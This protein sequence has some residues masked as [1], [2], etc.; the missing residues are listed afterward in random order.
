MLSLSDIFKYGSRLVK[1][2]KVLVGIE[3]KKDDHSENDRIVEI[4]KDQL[5]KSEAR[6]IE[7]D[8]RII[9]L[10]KEIQD[11]TRRLIRRGRK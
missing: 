4:L 11:L 6:E 8:K 1:A 10:E 3:D 2:G 7:Q 9:E 5:N